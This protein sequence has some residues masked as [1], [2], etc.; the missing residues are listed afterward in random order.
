MHRLIS[1]LLL[2]G[3]AIAAIAIEFAL[4]F[5]RP[6]KNGDGDTPV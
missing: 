2:I 5:L 6:R 3:V 1:I 4:G